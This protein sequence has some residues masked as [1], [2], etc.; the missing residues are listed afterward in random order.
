MGTRVAD[1][2]VLGPRYGLLIWNPDKPMIY[3]KCNMRAHT[4]TPTHTRKKRARVQLKG[5][6]FKPMTESLA[7]F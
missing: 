4:S 6:Y 2:L 7:K 5:R 3:V 1:S